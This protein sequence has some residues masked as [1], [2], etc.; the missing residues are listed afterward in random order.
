[1][2][3]LLRLLLPNLVVL[4]LVQQQH[5]GASIIEILDGG[6]RP[7]RH[8]CDALR[9]MSTV[10]GGG[11]MGGMGGVRGASG[12]R[13]GGGSGGAGRYGAVLGAV[14][15]DEHGDEID[16]LRNGGTQGFVTLGVVQRREAVA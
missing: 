10:G 14:L 16:R 4:L 13:G 7:R 5:Q 3:V 15:G 8:A 2:G 12:G 9:A 1:M 11:G 6:W